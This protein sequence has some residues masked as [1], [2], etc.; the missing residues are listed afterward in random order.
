MNNLHEYLFNQFKNCQD[1]LIKEINRPKT[2][3]E[4]EDLKKLREKLEKILENR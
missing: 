4:I 3:E 1:Y 2:P